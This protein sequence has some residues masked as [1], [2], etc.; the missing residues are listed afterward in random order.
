MNLNDVKK[1]EEARQRADAAATALKERNDAAKAQHLKKAA[2]EFRDYFSAAGFTVSPTPQGMIAAVGQTAFKL[3]LDS[4]DRF[5]A[6]GMVRITPPAGAKEEPTTVLLVRKQESHFTSTT[7]H[8]QALTP[9]QE[10]EKKA[11]DFEAALARPFPEMVFVIQK[12]AQA[13]VAPYGS[14]PKPHTSPL[15]G[16][17]ELFESFTEVLSKLY[18]TSESGL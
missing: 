12:V 11:A 18:P 2:D 8:A 1:L 13:H 9:L 4:N 6:F 17:R 3:E 10:M 16:S 7:F 15:S 5:G 14:R